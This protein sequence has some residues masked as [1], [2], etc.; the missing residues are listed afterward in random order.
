[1]TDM[2][3]AAL[4][5]GSPRDRSGGRIVVGIDDSPAGRAA[6]QWAVDLARSE[7]AQLVAV[8]SWALGLPRHGGRRRHKGNLHPHVV[9]FFDGA[10]QRD[11]SARL[12]RGAFRA[13]VGGLP[14][15]ITLTIKT[16]EGDPGVALTGIATADGDLLVVGTEEQ[17]S[18][19]RLVH[20]SVSQ[21]CCSHARCPV[22]VIPAA[23]DGQAKTMV[24]SGV[25]GRG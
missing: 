22:V 13:A 6:L 7:H 18:A 3:Q 15:D 17:F 10:E 19:R 16:P 14:R 8:R 24:L 25:A 12:V 1:V 9:L 23:P 11:A 20:G 5:S 4:A 2:E 21:Y